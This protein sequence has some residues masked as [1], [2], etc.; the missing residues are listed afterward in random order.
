LT[1]SIPRFVRVGDAFQAGV[2]VTVGSAPASVTVSLEV[3]ACRTV[4][5]RAAYGAV[6]ALCLQG[7]APLGFG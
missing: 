3:R 6:G 7:T 5:C 2:V 4:L 1:P